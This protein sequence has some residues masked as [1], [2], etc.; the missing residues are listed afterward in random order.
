MAVTTQ[1]EYEKSN[2]LIDSVANSLMDQALLDTPIE[3]IFE[4]TCLQLHAAGIPISRVQIGFRVL[5]PLFD[6]QTLTWKLGEK[7]ERSNYITSRD[8]AP[9]QKSPLYYLVVNEIPYLRRHLVGEDS[10]LDFDILKNL[11]EEG[12]TDYLAFIIP[13][14]EQDPKIDAQERENPG[15]VGSWSTQRENG[16]TN[17]NIQAIQRIERRLAVAFKIN[18]QSQI[19]TNILSAYLGP[20]AGN[21]VLNGSIQR[22]DGETIHAVIWYSDMR[23]STSL[24]NSISGKEFLQALNT[25]FESTAG[26][27]LNHGGEVL[28]FIGD[29]VLAIFPIRDEGAISKACQAAMNAAIEARKN[30]VD[31]NVIRNGDGEATLDF[32]LGL[33]VGQVLFGNIGVPERVEFSVIGRAANEVARIESLTKELGLPVLVSSEFAAN[34]STNWIEAGEHQLKGV[35]RP[36]RLFSPAQ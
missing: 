32:G 4:S 20:E 30:M 17:N 25:Y 27:V 13:F 33:H 7:V 24:A 14:S 8:P 2:S 19:T 28:R 5:H 9:W 22:G 15:I 18:I 21:Q 23:E 35:D 6:A 16:F 3:K 34:V 36:L 26:A 12:Y 1:R 11:K 10:I 31:A 29:A